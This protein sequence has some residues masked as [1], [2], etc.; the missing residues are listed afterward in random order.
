MVLISVVIPVFNGE[1]T[2]AETIHS[3]LDQSFSDFELLVIN[4]GS[5]DATLEV[6]EQILDPRLSIISY[7]KRWIVC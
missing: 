5:Q 3:V 4:D 1:T 2:I 7:E 6:V